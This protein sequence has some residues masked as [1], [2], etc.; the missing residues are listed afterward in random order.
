MALE[1]A[2]LNMIVEEGEACRQIVNQANFANCPTAEM[3]RVY[4]F[5]INS[6]LANLKQKRAGAW[7]IIG[8]GGIGAGIMAGLEI[9]GRF[10]GWW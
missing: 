7:H 4:L 2:A 1:D 10:K 6:S 9:Y 8:G 3:K 5:L